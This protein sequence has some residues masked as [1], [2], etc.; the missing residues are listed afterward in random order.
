MNNGPN[1]KQGPTFRT[2]R[3]SPGSQ[4]FW[5][6]HVRRNGFKKEYPATK[7]TSGSR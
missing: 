3:S 4:D 7:R 6:S 1:D 5:Q 2:F